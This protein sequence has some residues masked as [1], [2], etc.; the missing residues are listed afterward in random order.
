MFHENFDLTVDN[1]NGFLWENLGAFVSSWFKT[2]SPSGKLFLE[3]F[4]LKLGNEWFEHQ[5][6]I[7]L[8]DLPQP[9]NGE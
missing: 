2:A 3:T 4:R 8:E 7:T 5:I 9:V 6:Q 1:R